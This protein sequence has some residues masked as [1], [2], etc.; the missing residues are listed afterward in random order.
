MSSNWDDFRFFLTLSRTNSFVSAANQLKVTHST[1]SRRI[2]A[3]EADLQTKL[4]IRTEK[5]CRLTPAGEQLLPLAEEIEKTTQKL[6]EQVSGKDNQLSGTIRIGTPDGLGNCFLASKLSVLQRENPLLEVELIAVPMYFSLSK[7]EV[8]ILITVKKPVQDRVIA[9]KI[10]HYR[11]GLFASR[12]YLEQSKP[13]NKVSDLSGHRF[14]GYIDD[15]LYDQKLKF[16]EEYSPT[17]KTSFRSSTIIAQMNSIKAGAG[18]G[19]IPYFMVHTEPDLM[20][21]LPEKFLEREFWLQVSPDTKQLARARETMDFI[22]EQ[23][24]SQKNL[25]MLLPEG[26]SPSV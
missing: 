7:R 5:G 25:F 20:P 19:V 22:V 2:S 23:M 11:F 13:I 14:V 15:L 8:D 12:K 24:H 21:V 26:E 9:Q 3:L 17:L 6:Q 16:L 1:V 4:F 18:I 10:T